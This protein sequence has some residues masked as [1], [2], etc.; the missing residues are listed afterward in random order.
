MAQPSDKKVSTE[1]YDMQRLDSS[2]GLR[3]PGRSLTGV[4]ST[5][6][7]NL[8]SKLRVKIASEWFMYCRLFFLCDSPICALYLQTQFL[9]VN[10]W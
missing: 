3:R 4:A 1:R 9:V 5:P 10:N 6:T 2:P 8:V 7:S